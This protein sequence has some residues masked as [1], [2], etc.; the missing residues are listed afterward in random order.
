MPLAPDWTGVI[1]H[2][3]L[4][5]RAFLPMHNVEA[6]ELIAGKGIAGD[7]YLIGT[8]TGF[9]SAKPEDGRQIT[10]FEIEALA[11][12]ARD[13]AIAMAPGDH[14]RNVTVQGVPLNHL[15]GRRFRQ[16]R[17]QSHGA[18]VW[19]ELPHPRRRAGAARRCRH[20]GLRRWRRR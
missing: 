2:L 17:V 7:R 1:T 10:L 6:L 20:A 9:Y 13:Y 19:P 3:H 8:E 5:P 11:C 12:I 18:S 15:V 16:T 4:C 14:R